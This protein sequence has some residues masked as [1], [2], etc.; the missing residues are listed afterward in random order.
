MLYHCFVFQKQS[1]WL[2]NVVGCHATRGEPTLV[3]EFWAKVTDELLF[4][5]D[6]KFKIRQKDNESQ[7]LYG[8][9]DYHLTLPLTNEVRSKN[10]IITQ[11]QIAFNRKLTNVFL[12]SL[13]SV[14]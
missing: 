12:C 9:T 8:I 10:N 7:N 1:L 14:T 4:T 5:S 2:A 6:L 11:N 3:A 13:P